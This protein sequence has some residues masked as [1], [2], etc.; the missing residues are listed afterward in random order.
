MRVSKDTFLYLQ[1]ILTIYLSLFLEVWWHCLA[2]KK[3][4]KR[5]AASSIIPYRNTAEQKPSCL[6]SVTVVPCYLQNLTARGHHSFP[7][8]QM[9]SRYALQA[10]HSL[11][12]YLRADRKFFYL[13]LLQAT[14]DGKVTTNFLLQVVFQYLSKIKRLAYQ[15]PWQK[16]TP[17]EFIYWNS[18]TPWLP[19]IPAIVPKPTGFRESSSL[20]K[21]KGKEVK[22]SSFNS[23]SVADFTQKNS[24]YLISANQTPPHSLI[25]FHFYTTTGKTRECLWLN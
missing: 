10:L 1:H 11:V 4:K 14:T 15:V 8:N 22:D 20:R 25:F 23:S 19:D 12:V 16:C 6:W 24:A 17:F 7:S 3:K 21:R 2:L 13:Q 5:P 18:A 9:R